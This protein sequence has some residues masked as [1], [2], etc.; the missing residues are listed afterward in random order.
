MSFTPGG[1]YRWMSPELHDPEK[2]G[3]LGSGS[4]RP[5]RQSD[6]YA[7][8]MVIYEM[9]CGHVP[10]HDFAH[11]VLVINAAMGGFDRRNRRTRYTL[12]LLKYYENWLNNVGW[13]IGA[14]GRMRRISF[15]A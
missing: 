1:T 5:T 4:D 8:G 12:D 11:E 3:L 15:P 2:F 7:L 10:Y 9:L 14:H 6:C 13:K